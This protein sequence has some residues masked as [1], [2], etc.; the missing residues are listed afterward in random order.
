MDSKIISCIVTNTN[1]IMINISKGLTSL[2]NRPTFHNSTIDGVRAIAVLMVIIGHIFFFHNSDI[3]IGDEVFRNYATYWHLLRADLGVDLFF[4]ISGFLIG[5]ILFKEFKKTN[6]I[7]FTSFYLRRFL[8]LMPVYL[9]AILCGIYLFNLP[10]SQNAWANIFYINNFINIADQFM[11]WCW[12][13]AIEE[14][15]YILIPASLL[16]LLFSKRNK[17]NILLFFLVLSVVIRFITVYVFDLFPSELYW[18]L[19]G[20]E[21]W[22]L[23]FSI[24]YDNLL[25]RYGGLLIGVIAAYLYI[26]YNPELKL[27][28]K[29]KLSLRLF[30]V[31]IVIFWIVFFRIDFIYFSEPTRYGLMIAD[32]E[33]NFIEKIYFATVV[34]ITRNL[35]SIASIY[36]VFGALFLKTNLAEKINNFLSL[37]FFYPI[38]QLSYSA[39]LMHEMFMLKLYPNYSIM[40]YEL[41]NENIMMA[42]IIISL[43]TLILTFLSSIILYVFI[44]RPFME[45]RNS[46]IIKRLTRKK[47]E[48]INPKVIEAA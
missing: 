4:V 24:L 19:P 30:F 47:S 7:S 36:I 37:K 35:F 31:S 11:G 8:R 13:L 9:V 2:F 41:L 27:F 18:T 44:E 22:D 21:G 6:N 3:L 17:I 48:R 5:S 40:I 32:R 10:N 23:S 39:Y 38:A 20:K 1:L 42:L 34:S 15:F 12:S 29:S 14:Q 26:Y 16:M 43:I 25:T 28:F 45:F 46:N 33:L